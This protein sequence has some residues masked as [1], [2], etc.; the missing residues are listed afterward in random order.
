MAR[1]R[2]FDEQRVRDAALERFWR[3][4]FEA[5][6]IHD[7]L[8]CTG[9]GAASLYNAFGDKRSLFRQSLERY[10]D[11]GIGERLRRFETRPPRQA[12]QAFFD[13]VVQRS[14]DDAEHKGCMLVNSALEVAPHDA[15]LRELVVS[16]LD[17]IESFFLRCVRAGQRDA[18][19]TRG[20]AASEL[21]RHLLALL[22]GLRVLARVRPEK[23]LLEGAVR[24]AMIL[25]GPARAPGAPG[26]PQARVA[27]MNRRGKG[28]STVPSSS[29]G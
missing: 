1:P 3:D 10:V 15:Q 21:S 25:L 19:I 17:R 28:S 27:T 14:L 5:T 23:A 4:G 7:L 24:T 6:S 29:A 20:V 13:D 11:T 8:D 12:I 2:E 22:M 9:I 16:T 18:A 26:A